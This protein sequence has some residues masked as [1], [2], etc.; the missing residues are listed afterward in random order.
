MGCTVDGTL[1]VPSTNIF[2]TAFAITVIQTLEKEMSKDFFSSLI[3][4]K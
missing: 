4:I 3:L 1:G 2:L